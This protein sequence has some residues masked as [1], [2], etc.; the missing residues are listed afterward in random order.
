[1]NRHNNHGCGF[2]YSVLQTATLDSITQLWARDASYTSGWESQG[3]S[4]L[5]LSYLICAF[6]LMIHTH[7]HTQSAPHTHTHTQGTAS[8]RAMRRELLLL[9]IKYFYC[10]NAK[11]FLDYFQD[12][13]EKHF[14]VLRRVLLPPLV[15]FVQL[16][17]EK[18]LVVTQSHMGLSNNVPE[19]K[20]LM[21]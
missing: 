7:R 14:S 4:K 12:V 1:M 10:F 9:F 17:E 3:E 6:V 13:C 19:Q 2:D 5:C 8:G 21:S 18:T 20:S 11:F 15:L 16:S